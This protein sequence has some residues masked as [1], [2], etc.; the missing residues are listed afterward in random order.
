VGPTATT[1]QMMPFFT[2]M[3]RCWLAPLHSTKH[4]IAPLTPGF[5]LR[6]GGVMAI[7]A[8]KRETLALRQLH[9]ARVALC[10]VPKAVVGD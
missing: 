10:A 5:E 4:L 2:P 1:F 8:M 7:S 6:A 9:R 3:Q